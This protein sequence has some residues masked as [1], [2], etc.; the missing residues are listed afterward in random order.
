MAAFLANTMQATISARSL[1]KGT[2]SVTITAMKNPMRA[3]GMAKIVCSNF[4]RREYRIILF[5]GKYSE[6]GGITGPRRLYGNLII[7][8]YSK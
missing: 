5:I 4:T 3:K 2:W 1:Q 7:R 6:C 8:G